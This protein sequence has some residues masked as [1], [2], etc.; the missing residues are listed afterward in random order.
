MRG[1][2]QRELSSDKSIQTGVEIYIPPLILGI[3]LLA[4]V[5]AVCSPRRKATL[6]AKVASHWLAPG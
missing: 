2:E 6:A 4:F 5:D 3:K 1:V